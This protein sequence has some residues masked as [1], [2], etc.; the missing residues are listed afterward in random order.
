MQLTSKCI[1]E[2]VV[3][4]SLPLRDFDQNIGKFLLKLILQFCLILTKYNKIL[5][6][7]PRFFFAIMVARLNMKSPL[8]KHLFVLK[9]DV[10][11]K[12]WSLVH[13]GISNDGR[14][15]R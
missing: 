6:E 12:S 15:D 10:G 13:F 9:P 3:F 2:N 8:Q 1:V 5:A 4:E 11:V 14:V 7:I